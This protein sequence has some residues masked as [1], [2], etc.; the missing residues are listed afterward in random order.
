MTLFTEIA[1]IIVV[2]FIA[3]LVAYLLRQPII[4]GFIAA[5]FF[6]GLFEYIQSARVDLFG[7]LAS[8]GIALLLFLV[9]LDMDFSELKHVT[10]PA[11]L[12]G[13]GQILFTFGIGFVIVSAL[14]FSAITSFYI[15]AAITFSSTIIVIKLLSEKEDLAS[16]YGRIVVG[17]LLVQ[18]FVAILILMFVAGIHLEG[19]LATGITTALI[20]MTLLV[21]ITV[22]AYRV[23]PRI[24]NLIGRSQEMLYLFSIAWALGIAALAAAVGL[25][26]EIGGF[27][28]GLSLA[29][30]SEHFQIS[31]RLRPLRDF[32]IILF[33]V[34][35]GIQAFSVGL[36]SQ[37]ST[38]VVLSLFVLLGNPIIVLL[39][40][41]FLGHR[42]RTSFL[43]GISL[44][45]ISEFGLILIAL[46]YRLGDITSADVS[47]VTFVGV[48]TIFASSYFIVYG[49]KLYELFRPFA[50]YFE[51]RKNL[52][53]EIP[54]ETALSGHIIL[55]GVHRMGRSIL[56]ALSNSTSDFVAIDF[57][58]LVV[59]SLN[60]MKIPVV[61][62]DITDKDI[63]DRI[64]LSVAS[65]V[66]STIPTFKDNL[67]IL[68]IAKKN[69]Q[70][71]KIILTA[72]NEWQA[73][74]LYDEGADY[75]L[76]P[77]FIG[78]RELAS[79]LGEDTSLN[80]LSA[81]RKRDLRLLRNHTIN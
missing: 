64:G 66:I 33:F 23:L 8:I 24:L 2:A 65:A 72:E 60:A 57:D 9:G 48:I 71:T 34:G 21:G 41:G 7:G 68:N 53:E 32:F 73:H 58:P 36:I 59:K 69:K 17:I 76:I 40:M 35:L 12:A 63:Q 50:K 22:I 27:L 61:Y 15:A 54:K 49:D 55:V 5:G 42:A 19:S 14:G 16:L 81:L 29:S 51:F 52:I 30:S 1:L 67:A 46:G 6:I 3:G 39:I 45:Q 47:L 77:H 26:M 4:I 38:A 37:L 44:A 75:V 13:L 74:E 20:N 56:E 25:N 28:A 43:T 78:G 79:I 80:N 11:I 31:A 62:G 70:R 18:D 10:I